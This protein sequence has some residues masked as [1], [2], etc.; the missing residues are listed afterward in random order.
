MDHKKRLVIITKRFPYAN[1]EAFLEAEIGIASK[2]FDQITIFPRA[3]AAHKREVPAN[4]T[5]DDSLNS[6]QYKNVGNLLGTLVSP[7]FWKCVYDHRKKIT[8]VRDLKSSFIFMAQHKDLKKNIRKQKGL[9]DNTLVYTY[10]FN[11]AT[12]S[13]L[14]LRDKGELEHTTII[15][16]SHRYDLYEGPKESYRFWPYRAFSLDK[17]DKLFVISD[18]GQH[19]IQ[20]RYPSAPNVEIS[21]L[22]VFDNKVITKPSIEGI[23]VVSAAWVTERKRVDLIFK[24]L[25]RFAQEHKDLP[26]KWIHFGDGPLLETVRALTQTSPAL[27]NLEIVFKGKVANS[28]IISFYAH[29]PVDLFINLSS[30]EGVPV[31]IMEAQS[32]GIPVVAT[33]VG[34]S[35]EI[36][37]DAVGCLLSS[38]PDIAQVVDALKHVHNRAYDRAEIKENWTAKFNAE[39]NYNEFAQRLGQIHPKK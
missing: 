19:F 33:D 7:S 35:R 28:D 21:R 26:V 3:R 9:I 17:I 16:R 22:G 4:V 10:W 20:S 32:F 8:S 14:E 38:D 29:A 5:V 36:V 23:Q 37:N 18:D 34:A 15:S 6:E 1:T 39:K 25:H 27:D 12:Y 30:S 2:Y 11:D 31:S 13:L 24:S